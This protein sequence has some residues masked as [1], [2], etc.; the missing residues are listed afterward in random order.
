MPERGLT[1][2]LC[3]CGC[4][5]A[6]QTATPP[7]PSEATEPQEHCGDLKPQFSKNTDRTECVLRPGHTGSHADHN[8]TRWWWTDE[9]V[10]PPEEA[11]EATDTPGQ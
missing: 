8:N 7:A 4:H 2:Q 11:T 6:K 1:G 3:A 10:A 9:A 5:G